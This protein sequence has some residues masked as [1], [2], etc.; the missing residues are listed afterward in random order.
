MC[1]RKYPGEAIHA[2]VTFPAYPS[3]FDNPVTNACEVSTWKPQFT[4]DGWR[5][6]ISEFKQSL[7]SNTRLVVINFPHNPTG[8]SNNSLLHCI[9]VLCLVCGFVMI[10]Q[11]TLF[12]AVRSSHKMPL[13]VGTSEVNLVPWTQL[14][15][16]GAQSVVAQIKFCFT[17]VNG[18]TGCM[19]PGPSREQE[20]PFKMSHKQLN[21]FHITV[22]GPCHK[23]CTLQFIKPFEHSILEPKTNSVLR[24]K[25]LH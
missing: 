14:T 6:D 16:Y 19:W 20:M 17:K 12:F 7:K 18:V 2:V 24:G 3:L 9:F 21:L 1:C 11:F 8:F 23:Q 15:K 5:F 25:S 22:Y 13:L 10:V 4:Q